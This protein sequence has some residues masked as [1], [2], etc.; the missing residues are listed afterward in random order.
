MFGNINRYSIKYSIDKWSG[1]NKWAQKIKEEKVEEND[2]ELG[3]ES[4]PKN[5]HF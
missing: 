1:K 3:Q 4:Q 2:N 5:S